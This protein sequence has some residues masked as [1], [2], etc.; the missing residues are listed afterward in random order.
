[1]EG[2]ADVLAE[3]AITDTPDALPPPNPLESQ[4]VRVARRALAEGHFI[5]VEDLLTDAYSSWSNPDGHDVSLHYAESYCLVRFLDGAD[6]PERQKQFRELAGGAVKMNG[7]ALATRI[8]RAVHRLMGDG[9]AFERELEQWVRT[10]PLYPWEN[11]AGDVRPLDADRFVLD[12]GPKQAGLALAEA[13]AQVGDRVDVDLESVDAKEVGVVFAARAP[14]DFWVFSHVD[15]KLVLGRFNNKRFVPLATRR[16]D[17]PTS[18]ARHLS[19]EL[20]DH[21]VIVRADDWPEWKQPMT[22][23]VDGRWGLFSYDGE[24]RIDRAIKS[25]R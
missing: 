13:P 22:D 3:R 14:D 21:Q 17:A 7:F 15:R 12:T 1:V 6:H 24:T 8:N 18:R 2:L 19:V 11:L 20:G 9:A 5:R 25:T 4:R 23:A 16:V 10:T